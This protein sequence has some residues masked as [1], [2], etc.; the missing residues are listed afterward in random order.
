MRE[1][2][3]P[4]IPKNA[5]LSAMPGL[6]EEIGMSKGL[7]SGADFVGA[8][9]AAAIATIAMRS[10][11]GHRRRRGATGVKCD[12]REHSLQT[13]G[14][15]TA[16]ASTSRDG[17]RLRPH[18]QHR[19]HDYPAAL[20]SI[21]TAYDNAFPGVASGIATGIAQFS[22][23]QVVTNAG[24]FP[25][26]F[27]Y[28]VTYQSNGAGGPQIPFNTASATPETIAVVPFLIPAGTPNGNYTFTVNT[29]P[30]TTLVSLDT[31]VELVS[32]TLQTLNGTLTVTPVDSRRS[33]PVIFSSFPGNA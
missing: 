23:A 6:G 18:R 30:A 13:D 31:T 21:A 33:T 24:V 8:L 7:G 27:T 15:G 26:R 2:D 9:V 14:L 28:L 16:F 3:V 5:S 1:R 22:A 10:G 25:N 32:P 20:G 11:A 12:A 29:G 19:H 17:E 4:G